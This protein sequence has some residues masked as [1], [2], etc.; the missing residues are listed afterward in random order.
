MGVG[1][2]RVGDGGGL[3]CGRDQG[4]VG[5]KG[6]GVVGDQKGREW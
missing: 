6:V 4:V 2:G 3:R 5:I 1:S